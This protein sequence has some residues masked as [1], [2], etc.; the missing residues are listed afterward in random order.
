MN[1]ENDVVINWIDEGREIFFYGASSRAKGLIKAFCDTFPTIKPEGVIDKSLAGQSINVCGESREILSPENLTFK[2]SIGIVLFLSRDVSYNAVKEMLETMGF[3]YGTHFIR[4]TNLK[5]AKGGWLSKYRYSDISV[6]ELYSPWLTD[7]AFAST[8]EKIKANTL[9]DELRCYEL[10]SL[11]RQT[12]QCAGGD[13]LEVGVWRGG[14][15]ALISEAARLA[16]IDA[17]VYLADTFEGVVKV[18]DADLSY[19]GGE[20]NDTSESIV[21]SLLDRMELSNVKI[22]KGIFPDDF[23]NQFDDTKYRFVHIDVDIYE[24][25][26]DVF[27]YIWPRVEHGG[28]VVFDDYGNMYTSGVTELCDNLAMELSDGFFV[29]NMNKHGVFI[30]K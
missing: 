4:A 6:S 29:Y 19:E 14:T 2:A 13:I 8:M 11:V 20:H 26:K 1:Y 23:G 18:T 28:C 30:K 25:A 3:K 9:V 21:Q 15:G 10:W 27:N 17:K 24:S 12:A 16:G 5:D 7:E 22:L